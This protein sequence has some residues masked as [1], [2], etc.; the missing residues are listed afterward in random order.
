MIHVKNFENFLN[1]SEDFNDYLNQECEKINSI[2]TYDG[3][4]EKVTYLTMGFLAPLN[5]GE[6]L[7]SILRSKIAEILE[8]ESEENKISNLTQLLTMLEGEQKKFQIPPG[9]VI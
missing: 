4:Y 2:S 1:E 3:L 8:K 6:P 9:A 7:R 5:P